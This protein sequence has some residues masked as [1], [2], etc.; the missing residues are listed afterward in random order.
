MIRGIIV[1]GVACMLGACATAPKQG[2]S[3]ASV[4]LLQSAR[5]QNYLRHMKQYPKYDTHGGVIVSPVV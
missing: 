1:L 4:E 2:T 3:L 5:Y